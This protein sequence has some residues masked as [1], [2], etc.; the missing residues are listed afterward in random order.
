VILLI[1][2]FV[3]AL[4]SVPKTARTNYHPFQI[5]VIAIFYLFQFRIFIYAGELNELEMEI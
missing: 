2:K 3:N 4:E 5:F 1:L